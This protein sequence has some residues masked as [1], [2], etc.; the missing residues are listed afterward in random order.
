MKKVISG[1][2]FIILIIGFVVLGTKNYRTAEPTDSELF[3]AEYQEID[4][5]NIFVYTNASKV[6]GTLKNGTGIIFFGFKS[7]VWAGYYANILNDAAMSLG[8]EQIY[9]YDFYEDR[10]IHNATYESIV[11]LLTPYLTVLDDGTKNLYSPSMVI[12]KDGQVVAFNDD[13]A[14]T[15]GASSP[16]KYWTVEQTNIETNKLTTLINENLIV[17]EDEVNE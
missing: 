16:E 12:V 11:E 7:N 1:I 2:I 13:T 8:V 9:Y 10:E 4:E 3:S 5:N 17:T 14:F 15:N 6:L